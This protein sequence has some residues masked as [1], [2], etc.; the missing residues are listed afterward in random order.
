M[1]VSTAIE[2]T[3][4]NYLYSGGVNR[5][6]FDTLASGITSSALSLTTSGLENYIS[7]GTIIEFDDSSMELALTKETESTTTVDLNERGYLETTAAAHTAGIKLWLDPK[8]PRQSIFDEISAVVGDLY[9]MGLYRALTTT[10]TWSG[11]SPIDL[12]AT[13][14]D[15]LR[16]RTRTGSL[17]W[18]APLKKGI[19]YDVIQETTP[20]QI[21][22]YTGFSSTVQVTYKADFVLPTAIT[23]DLTDD[24]GVPETL[25]PYIPAAVA[26]ALLVGKEVPRVQVDE[27]RR[28]L[29]TDGISVGANLQVG[30][31]LL[32]YFDRKVALERR[33]L[34]EQ[35]PVRFERV[36]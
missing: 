2:K 21:Q 18:D 34:L 22:L 25:A 23:D 27:I 36:P 17:Q 33:R 7:G 16:V 19:D 24:C 9:P 13:A 6:S 32:G 3:L 14:R 15:V 12:P 31:S 8:F 4:N 28:S 29:A 10:V 20:R 35:T 11:T 1:L 5:P 26:G 30:Q